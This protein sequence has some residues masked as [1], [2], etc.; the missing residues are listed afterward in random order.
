M[1]I[2]YALNPTIPAYREISDGIREQFKRE[3]GNRFFIHSEYLSKDINPP[4][5]TLNKI[6]TALNEKYDKIKIDLMICVGIDAISSIQTYASDYIKSLPCISVDFDLSNYGIENNLVLNDKTAVFKMEID[7]KKILEAAINL[8]PERR[9]LYFICG[10]SGPDRLYAFMTRKTL[11][12]FGDSLNYTFIENK[13]MDE[14]LGFVGQLP[15]E[16]LIIVSGMVKDAANVN[17][18]NPE[19]VRLI[20]QSSNVPIFT[21]SDMGFGEGALGG[22]FL[23]FTRIG[24]AI[25]K[26]GVEIIK[27]AD[28]KLFSL[29]QEDY[30][31][32]MFDYRELQKFNLV[33]S[34]LLPRGSKIMFKENNF[35]TRYKWILGFI[36]L[37]LLLQ[38]ILIVRL[39]MLNRRQKHLALQ[40]KKY[41]TKSWDLISQDRIMRMG[42]LT[43]SLSHELNQPLTA[44]LSTAQAGIRFIESGNY[45]MELIK[46]IIT[47]IIHDNQRLASI[48]SSLR[49]MMKL[50]KRKKEPVDLNTLV[51]DVSGIFSGEAIRYKT[52]LILEL[53]D[54]PVYI[55]A[56]G[57]QIQQIILNFL[58]NALQSLEK[59]KAKKRMIII[60]ETKDYD[61]VKVSVRD[62]GEGI[63]DEIKGNL[64]QPFTT[65]K[66]GGIGI[67]L[68]VCKFIVL[69]HMG[70]ISAQNMPDGGAEFSFSLKKFKDE[71]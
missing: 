62:F 4:A 13:T 27:D 35:I 20:R 40:L 8:F 26:T 36:I 53:P 3:F 48:L 33:N 14:I 44:M 2:I 41:E 66:E 56:D 54:E 22:Y 32:V 24:T 55:L 28:P 47:D 31:D 12:T 69:E 6:F 16:S 15:P 45:T 61:N 39:I 49:G 10:R 17:Y 19:S 67:G 59:A 68:S 23:I 63:S 57:I 29:K 25:G 9:N 11:E 43:A 50:E 71:G 1:L 51:K 7:I 60:T 18:Y 46:E 5:D 70:K 37:F 64:F 21:Y 65:S 38:S 34:K 58:M 42:Q 52:E 30:Y